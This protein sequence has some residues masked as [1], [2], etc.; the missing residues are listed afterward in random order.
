MIQR[1]SGSTNPSMSGSCAGAMW[2]SNPHAR[3]ETTSEPRPSARLVFV[4]ARSDGV[5]SL[6][7]G[8]QTAS[9]LTLADGMLHL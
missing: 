8:E 9:S 4:H 5:L 3:T 6:G 1:W 7:T 2:V